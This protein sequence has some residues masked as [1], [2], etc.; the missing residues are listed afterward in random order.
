MLRTVS[1]DSP[2]DWQIKAPPY[3]VLDGLFMVASWKAPARIRSKE[4]VIRTSHP[5][6][7]LHPC[8]EQSMKAH[9]RYNVKKK[10]CTTA[11][12]SR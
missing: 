10:S 3:V 2:I 11:T 1:G 6:P 8:R 12:P 5:E 4:K 9:P 7:R